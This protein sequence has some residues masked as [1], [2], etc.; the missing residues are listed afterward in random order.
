MAPLA[1]HA[2]GEDNANNRDSR[3]RVSATHG[4]TRAEGVSANDQSQNQSNRRGLSKRFVFSLFVL[5]F[6][7]LGIRILALYPTKGAIIIPVFVIFIIAISPCLMWA[8]DAENIN[9]DMTIRELLVKLGV[10]RAQNQ[11][12][13]ASIDG[14]LTLPTSDAVSSLQQNAPAESLEN[15]LTSSAPRTSRAIEY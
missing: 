13:V 12:D 15:T 9:G 3:D 7:I 8:S 11:V 5:T 4:E 2:S 14:N 1:E 10:M 6:C